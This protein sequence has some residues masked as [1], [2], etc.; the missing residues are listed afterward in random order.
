V[1]HRFLRRCI[2]QNDILSIRKWIGH[3]L[4]QS[5]AKK[6]SANVEHSYKQ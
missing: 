2:G 3:N 1:A 5:A 4:A 6:E